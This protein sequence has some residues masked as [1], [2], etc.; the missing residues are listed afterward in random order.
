MGKFCCLPLFHKSAN[1]D[2][3][4]AEVSDAPK[5]K[6]VAVPVNIQIPQPAKLAGG[7]YDFEHWIARNNTTGSLASS[8]SQAR[9]PESFLPDPVGVEFDSDSDD[10]IRAPKPSAGAAGAV[11]TLA[12][13]LSQ[14]DKK[15]ASASQAKLHPDEIKELVKR[16]EQR[17]ETVAYRAEVRRNS[18][19]RI[20]AQ[21]DIGKS[22]NSSLRPASSRSISTR[23]SNRVHELETV[24]EDPDDHHKDS[25]PSGPRDDVEFSVVPGLSLKDTNYPRPP[26][27][28]QNAKL[29]AE[30]LKCDPADCDTDD[31]RRSSCPRPET[32]S[33]VSA[34]LQERPSLPMM[35][36]PPTL[37]A[38]QAPDDED[39]AS[40]RTWELSQGNPQ[41]DSQSTLIIQAEDVANEFAEATTDAKSKNVSE[42][43]HQPD[44][45]GNKDVAQNDV[46]P[47]R[48]FGDVIPPD[49]SHASES[50]QSQDGSAW[51]VWLLAQELG[52]PENPVAAN[53]AP[54][55][56]ELVLASDVSTTCSMQNETN[57]KV[58]S[59]AATLTS[60]GTS[61]QLT[62]KASP[63]SHDSPTDLQSAL[64]MNLEME[65]EMDRMIRQAEEEE[66]TSCQER[67]AEYLSL[68]VSD[69]DL[70]KLDNSKESPQSPGNA[71]DQHFALSAKGEEEN[72]GP[73]VTLKMAL[74]SATSGY[75]S[76][77]VYSSTQNTRPPSLSTPRDASSDD[78]VRYILESFKGLELSPFSGTL[79]CVASACQFANCKAVPDDL[80]PE[81]SDDSYRT[82]VS[83]RSTSDPALPSIALPSKGTVSAEN[84]V[85]NEK[86]TEGPAETSADSRIHSRK[87]SFLQILLHRTASGSKGHRKSKS[88]P[89]AKLPSMNTS[90]EPLEAAKRLGHVKKL[91]NLSI[92]SNMQPISAPEVFV[93]PKLNESATAVW[94]RAFELEHHR[95]DESAL[96]SSNRLSKPATSERP[97]AGADATSVQ[98]PIDTAVD[99]SISAK[100]ISLPTSETTILV[101][102]PETDTNEA[103]AGTN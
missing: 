7:H 56:T 94:Q 10:E 9:T 63:N 55:Q 88:Q 86:L 47:G 51:G 21:A 31:R 28:P 89:S 50:S 67:A 16:A 79:S 62:I 23:G 57:S 39:D 74:A 77:S 75:P 53:E 2:F 22:E 61:G 64:A 17:A 3:E 19:A 49:R 54:A 30:T 91:S 20:Q 97:F 73:N 96:H 34:V 36:P 11:R 87:S 15:R 66:E 6:A 25:S 59:S 83:E 8:R 101:A 103:A 70:Q 32:V 29:P 18:I 78:N 52:S 33:K 1:A 48:F 100:D 58:L 102:A 98:E 45:S 4:G 37:I 65:D 99:A 46:Q 92:R 69:R 84:G 85:E 80:R 26:A 90:S 82:A 81:R 38:K 27:R 24:V 72:S 71:H 93:A 41:R 68:K 44:D 40:L 60:S 76:S 35:P 95:R 12:R 13:R 42:T 43:Q 14:D 5:Q